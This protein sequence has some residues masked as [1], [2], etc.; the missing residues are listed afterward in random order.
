MD[1]QFSEKES[2][3]CGVDLILG[4]EVWPSTSKL[5]SSP[6]KWEKVPP[7]INLKELS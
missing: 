2:E 4:H 5:I 1:L 3:K 7:P 6:A